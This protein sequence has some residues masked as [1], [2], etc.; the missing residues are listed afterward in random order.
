MNLKGKKKSTMS[1]T[2]CGSETRLS[3][4][5]SM[6]QPGIRGVSVITGMKCAALTLS[7]QLILVSCVQMVINHIQL[8]MLA[9]VSCILRLSVRC[10]L[11]KMFACGL[12]RAHGMIRPSGS[13]RQAASTGNLCLVITEDFP[14]TAHAEWVFFLLNCIFWFMQGCHRNYKLDSTFQ[15]N[16]GGAFPLFQGL[17]FILLLFA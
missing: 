14:I 10:V 6:S 16:D 11:G 13:I 8:D 15:N 12:S 9:G 2:V 1:Q 7:L 3:W 17:E 5:W 4:H